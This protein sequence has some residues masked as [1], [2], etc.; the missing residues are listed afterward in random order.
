ME[1]ETIF[2]KIRK[3]LWRAI[4]R[5]A[6]FIGGD[7]ERMKNLVVKNQIINCFEE[8][9]YKDIKRNRAKFG[10]F[11]RQIECRCTTVILSIYIADIEGNALIEDVLM[12]FLEANILQVCLNDHAKQEG[13]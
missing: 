9:K 13:R 7:H 11:S 2:N 6:R 10:S 4:E 5:P 3:F 12:A 1:W 8:R